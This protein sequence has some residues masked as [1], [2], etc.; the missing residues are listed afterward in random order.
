MHKLLFF[1]LLSLSVQ[2]SAAEAPWVGVDLKNLPCNGGAQGY[3]PFDYTNPEHQSYIPIVEEHHFNS[4]VE[5]HIKGQE[6]NIVGDIDYTL[7]AIPN[8]HRAL[9]SMIRYQLKINSHLI[10]DSHLISKPECYLQ[11]A[12]NFSPKDAATLS[13]YAHYLKELN[14]FEKAYKLYKG[15]LNI[16]PNNAKIAYSFSLMLI[17]LKQYE[18]ALRYAKIAYQYKNTPSGLKNKLK[19]LGLWND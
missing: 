3:G 18:D 1:T 15:A 4:N 14:F 10:T 17:D 13:L 12:I 16:S 2:I 9:I 19:K 8:H 11:R 6:G 7:R 5:N